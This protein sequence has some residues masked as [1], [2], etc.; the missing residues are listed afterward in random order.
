MFAEVL[1]AGAESYANG[2]KTAPDRY[3]ADL[4]IGRHTHEPKPLGTATD[5]AFQQ[6]LRSLWVGGWLPVDLWQIVSRKLDTRARNLLVDGIAAEMARYAPA[7]VHR[8]W[9]AQLAEIDAVR[10]WDS[11]RP[12]LG[13]W[14]RRQGIGP[15]AAL[16]IAITVLGMLLTLP[17][18][19]LILPPPG[20]ATRLDGAAHG[21]DEK[22]LSRVRGLLAKA[23]STEYPDEAEALSAKA[24]E[25]MNRHAFE[26]ALLDADEHKPYNASSRRVWLDTPYLDAKAHLVQ[27]VADANRARA[28]QYSNLGFVALVGDE[29]DLEITELLMTSL[30]IQATRAMLAQGRQTARG[31]VSRTRSFRQSFLISYAERIGERLHAAERAAAEAAEDPRLLPMLADRGKAVDETFDEMF[32]NL[33]Q[34]SMPVSSAAGWRAGRHAADQADLTLDRTAVTSR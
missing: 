23:E 31:G 3:A 15:E 18:L 29:L 21:V 9:E 13:Q 2:D 6:I 24:Q 26:R 16:S 34:K 28:A 5:M 11:S 20:T 10:W 7:T 27:A 33:V 12:H 25:L 19:P 30:L 1:L 32:P 4:V 22:V 8:R 17:K 14:T